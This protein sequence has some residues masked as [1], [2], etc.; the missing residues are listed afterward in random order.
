MVMATRKRNGP[1]TDYGARITI[2]SAINALNNKASMPRF[3]AVVSADAI[4][5][6]P[7]GPSVI[8]IGLYNWSNTE[9]NLASFPE[10]FVAAKVPSR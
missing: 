9:R 10:A 2:S 5:C 6:F 3:F 1:T 4:G 7:P 8:T